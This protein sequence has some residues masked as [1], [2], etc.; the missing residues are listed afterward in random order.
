MVKQIIKHHPSIHGMP[1]ADLKEHSNKIR[2]MMCVFILNHM[3]WDIQLYIR[4]NISWFYTSSA[5]SRWDLNTFTERGFARPPPITFAGSVLWSPRQIEAILTGVDQRI[6]QGRKI[7]GSNIYIT[8]GLW[9]SA[10]MCW[11]IGKRHEHQPQTL[12]L[13]LKKPHYDKE[14]TE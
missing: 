9:L 14:S 8:G 2:L 1:E 13:H 6:S 5:F 3:G 7:H 11:V 10:W 12:E 4:L